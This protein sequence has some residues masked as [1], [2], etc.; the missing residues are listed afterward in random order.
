MTPKLFTL[1]FF[2]GAAL[3]FVIYALFTARGKGPLLSSAYL[4]ATRE[5]REK[6]DKRAEYR[7]LTVMN[8][9]VAVILAVLGLYCYFGAV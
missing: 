3:I 9:V 5:E 7:K 4:R 2:L 6:M 8:L 1:V